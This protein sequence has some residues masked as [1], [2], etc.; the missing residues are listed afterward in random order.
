MID[1]FFT[2]QGEVN[3]SFLWRA[4]LTYSRSN[5]VHSL[6]YQ[7]IQDTFLSIALPLGDSR[8]AQNWT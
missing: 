1:S 6:C 8:D 3:E 2:Y 7:T 4:H 5:R